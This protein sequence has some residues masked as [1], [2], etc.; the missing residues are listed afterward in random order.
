VEDVETLK[1]FLRNTFTHYKIPYISITPTFSIC[2]NHGYLSG[3]H[4]TCPDCGIETEVWSR[5]TGYLRPVSSFNKGKK[6]EYK[7][8]VKQRI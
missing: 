6:D 3:E 4:F 5:V 1:G 2:S 8:R 7:L